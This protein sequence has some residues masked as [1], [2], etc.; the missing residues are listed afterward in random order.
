MKYSTDITKIH[1]FLKPEYLK[2]IFFFFL[3]GLV[4]YLPTPVGEILRFLVLKCFLKEIRTVWIR[5]GVTFWFPGNIRIGRN[6]SLNEFC[7]L[8]GAAPIVIGN[9]V[10]IG[11][12]TSIV[13]DDHGIEDLD[14]PIWDQE[15]KALPITIEDNVYLGCRVTVLKGVTI[16]SGAVV[17]AGSV[18]TRDVPADSIVAGVP[19]QVVGRR[20]KGT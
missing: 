7:V 2:E 4:K 20:R 1:T 13:T 9:Q 5:D 12:Q 17:A 10:L 6:V 11:H 19:A 8:N 15:K 18:V 14:A 3:Y 16:H